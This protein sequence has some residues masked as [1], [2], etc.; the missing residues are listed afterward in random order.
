MRRS[1]VPR[2][3]RRLAKRLRPAT[4]LPR[5]V[6]SLFWDYPERRLSLARDRELII[7]RILAEGGLRHMRF[8]RRRVGDEAIRDVLVSSQARGL[9]PQRIRFWQLLL[10]V[11]AGLANAWV[12]SARA[13]TWARRQ[14]P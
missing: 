6:T 2:P 3:Q 13:G 4:S 9:S 7:R 5:S 14:R 1:T 12:R 10:D 8:I 11:P